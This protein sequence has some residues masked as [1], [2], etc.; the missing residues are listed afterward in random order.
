MDS[1]DRFM[2]ASEKSSNENSISHTLEIIKAAFPFFDNQTQ[3]AMDLVLK[4]GELFETFHSISQEGSLTAL[5]LHKSPIDIEGL[6]NA[7]RE[8]CNQ[9]EREIVDMILNFLRAKNLYQTYTTL[10]AAMASQSGNT[11]GTNYEDNPE[12]Q[13]NENSGTNN[14]GSLFGMDGNPNMMELLESFLTP[15]QK[16]TFDNLNMMLN[17]MQ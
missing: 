17:V 14:M 3:Q 2:D 16:S 12:G 5:S 7:I 15:E 1:T 11:E 9:K 6:L 13:Y 10:T 4:T 8:V